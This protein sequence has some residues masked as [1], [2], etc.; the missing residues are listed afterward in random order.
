[1]RRSNWSRL[2]PLGPGL[3]L[4]PVDA[5]LATAFV[6]Q[7]Q[8]CWSLNLTEALVLLATLVGYTS[9]DDVAQAVACAVQTSRNTKRRLRHALGVRRWSQVV[10]RAWAIYGPLRAALAVR[11]AGQEEQAA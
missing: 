9:D 8:Q 4:D 6:R 7:A 3:P 11:Q 5:T 2:P 10:V 1:M